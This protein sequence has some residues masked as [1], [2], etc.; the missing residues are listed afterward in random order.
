VHRVLS[1][2]KACVNDVART[3]YY[4]DPVAGLKDG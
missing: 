3:I 1:R 2:C 4:R